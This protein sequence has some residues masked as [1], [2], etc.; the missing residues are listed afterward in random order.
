[1]E[2]PDWKNSPDDCYIC[3]RSRKKVLFETAQELGIS[4]IVYA[5]NKNDV[6]ETFLMNIIYSGNTYTM[7]PKQPFFDGKFD[8]IRPFYNVE[9]KDIIRYCRIYQIDPQAYSCKGKTINKRAKIRDILDD[10][11]KDQNE[12]RSSIIHR[13]FVSSTKANDIK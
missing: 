11:E 5:H 12:K 13:I 8:V 4:K 1:L 10:L 2:N 3:A 6:A 7:F 9:V